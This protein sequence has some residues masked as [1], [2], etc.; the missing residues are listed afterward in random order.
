M[1]SEL[2]RSVE[3]QQ[4]PS[5]SVTFQRAR[6]TWNRGRANDASINRKIPRSGG[7]SSWACPGQASSSW[8]LESAHSSATKR[9]PGGGGEAISDPIG[10]TLAS[11]ET[12]YLISRLQRDWPP[13][14]PKAQRGNCSRCFSSCITVIASETRNHA[15]AEPRVATKICTPRDRGKKSPTVAPRLI[16][17]SFMRVRMTGARKGKGHRPTYT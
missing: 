7:S 1:V 12:G 9:R 5:T 14:Y 8:A 16:A 15:A 11:T 17:A 2:I 3:K 6:F 4:T 10:A 13:R